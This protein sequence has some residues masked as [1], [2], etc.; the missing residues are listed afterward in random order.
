M[1]TV[2]KTFRMAMANGITGKIR[3]EKVCLALPLD[4]NLTDEQLAKVVEVIV[5]SGLKNLLYRTQLQEKLTVHDLLEERKRNVKIPGE[6]QLTT[7][8]S[9][10]LA[11]YDIEALKAKA[12]SK[13]MNFNSEAECLYLAAKKMIAN[14]KFGKTKPTEEQCVIIA[15]RVLSGGMVVEEVELF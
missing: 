4:E 5:T 6:K 3:G 12:K 13:K 15:Q 10:I 1:S 8:Y 2:E 14:L 11:K 9:Q 7:L